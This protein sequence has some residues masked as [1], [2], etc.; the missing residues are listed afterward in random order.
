MFIEPIT[1]SNLEWN[2]DLPC[3]NFPAPAKT[4]DVL[5]YQGRFGNIG[6][7]V[8][9]LMA[10]VNAEEPRIAI[11]EDGNTVP[12]EK[13]GIA[14]KLFDDPFKLF[15]KY[16]KYI[17]KAVI[18][19]TDCLD[20]INLACTRAGLDEAV[21]LTADDYD[22][23]GRLN[24]KPKIIADYRGK[25]LIDDPDPKVK[26]SK[27]RLAVYNYLY[28]NY[29]SRCTRKLITSLPPELTT[30]LRDYSMAVKSAII[31]LEFSGEEGD[32]ANK[33]FSHTHTGNSAALGWAPNG[34]EGGIVTCASL[35][36]T[37][38]WASDFSLSM[39]YFAAAK[40][41][42]PKQKLKTIDEYIDNNG[43]VKPYAYVAMAVSD[44]D[45]LQYMQRAMFE[46]FDHPIRKNP[47]MP[48]ISWTINPAAC[49][50]IPA[51]YNYYIHTQSK[52]F[53]QDGFLT[54]PSGVGYFYP[55]KM[56]KSDM[57]EESLKFY[58]QTSRYCQKTGIN[59]VSVWFEAVND[60]P[61]PEEFMTFAAPKLSKVMSMFFQRKMES[62]THDGVLFWGWT[63]PYND[64]PVANFD[65]EIKAAFEDAAAKSKATYVSLQGVPWD[66]KMLENFLQVRNTADD[67][68]SSGKKGSDLI[69]YVTIDQLVQ[70]QRLEKGLP[71]IKE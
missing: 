67:L 65:K 43:K 4:A 62:H 23:L 14:F 38:V 69:K 13:M 37:Y 52:D 66:V 29:Y 33:F 50:I 31:F 55:F 63:D 45:N 49:D 60:P 68:Q 39:T 18:W 8:T 44:G 6:A 27:Q 34:D 71:R 1:K 56:F 7:T 10:I 30:Q 53:P 25:F 22:T 16:K 51:I 17:T 12:F 15:E 21:V 36:G 32:L 61:V 58:D 24:I 70:L 59:T 26:T 47:K 35:N 9:S 64:N 46:L 42:T 48:A 2:A 3:M 41:V 28:D 5:V 20:T 11:A 40:G 54:G 19:D 57:R